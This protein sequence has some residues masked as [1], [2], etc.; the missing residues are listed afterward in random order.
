VGKQGLGKS[1]TALREII[2]ISMVDPCTHMLIIINKDG[3]SND[4]TYESLKDLIRIPVKF[5]SYSDAEAKVKEILKYKEFYNNVKKRHI[6]D[7]I[8]DDQAEE[9]LS[10]LEID[11]FSRP[12]LHTIIYFEDCANNTCFRR[13]VQYFP[14]LIATCRHNGI[15]FFFTTQFWKGVPTELKSNATTIY[16]FRDFSKQ[17]ISYILQ[18]TPLKHDLN[19]VYQSYKRLNNHDRMVVDTV[20]GTIIIDK[21]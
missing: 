16:I 9:T 11:D 20:A 6:E 1:Y 17:Q 7:Q 13:S 10:V 12:Y 19:V 5:Y 14:Q 3:R 4:A 8:E 18:Q 21:T 2:K 15:S